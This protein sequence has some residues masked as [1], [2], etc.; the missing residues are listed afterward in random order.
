MSGQAAMILRLAGVLLALGLAAAPARAQAPHAACR[1]DNVHGVVGDGL[2]L[3]LRSFAPRRVPRDP[4]LVVFLHGNSGGPSVPVADDL[5]SFAADLA[6]VRGIVAVTLTRPGHTGRDGRIA[7][8]P[9]RPQLLPDSPDVPAVAEAIV[10]LKRHYRARRVV[11]VGFSGGSRL[12]ARMVQLRLG[13]FDAG[14]LYACPC[15]DPAAE[16]ASALP[17]GARAY[18]RPLRLTLITGTSDTGTRGGRDFARVLAAR[19]V[20]ASF[21]PLRGIGHVFDDHVWATTLRPS[22]LRLAQ[23]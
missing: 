1:G 5:S 22:L 18:P 17:E 20:Q 19:H 14:L 21:R 3:P 11:V 4:T 12:I 2:C 8:G 9:F 13:S 7:D 23:H 10:R 6:R 16:I 15:E